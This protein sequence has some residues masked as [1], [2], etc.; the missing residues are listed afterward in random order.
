MSREKNQNRRWGKALRKLREDAGLTQPQLA[1]LMGY[2][3]GKGK[4]SEIETGSLPITEE[5][6]RLWIHICRKTMFDFYATATQYEAGIDRLQ[7]FVF[8]E[9]S[10]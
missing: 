4:I 10:K 1:I 6:I 3:N 7:P 9:Q 5:K 8:P 2:P